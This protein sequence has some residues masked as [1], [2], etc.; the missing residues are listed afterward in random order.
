[1]VGNEVIVVGNSTSAPK[2]EQGNTPYAMMPPSPP[3]EYVMTGGVTEAT[4][5]SMIAFIRSVNIYDRQMEESYLKGVTEVLSKY[6]MLKAKDGAELSSQEI[7]DQAILFPKPYAVKPIILRIKTRGGYIDEGLA[8]YDVIRESKTP[9]IAIVHHAYSMGTIISLACDYVYCYKSSKFMIH[10]GACGL[11]GK[12]EEIRDHLDVFETYTMPILKEV[13]MKKSNLTEEE[14]EEIV[15]T[16]KDRY[17]GAKEMLGFG[18]VDGILS[19]SDNGSEEILTDDDIV[20]R[21]IDRKIKLDNFA[22]APH[23]RKE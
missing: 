18:F 6:T 19:Y 21:E 14:F 5:S 20:N 12:M 10:D 3:R 13:Y 2:Q 11:Q 16:R 17:Y 1:M 8:L 9:V 4:V 22:G 15:R 7:A 23:Y